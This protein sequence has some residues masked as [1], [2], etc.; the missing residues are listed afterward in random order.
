MYSTA[1]DLK[2][3]YASRAGRMVRRLIF[4]HI[5]AMWPD[6]KGLR[7]AAYGYGAPYLRPLME[8]AE[9]AV[10]LMPAV[11]GAHAWPEQADENNLACLVDENEW[12]LETESV[13][14]ILIVHGLEQAQTPDL[15]LQECWRVLKSN[16]RLV[17]VVPNRIGFWARSDWTPFGR[18]TPY[19]ISQI[20]QHLRNSLFVHERTEK[21]LFLPAF[22]S[23][24][25]LRTAYIFESIGRAVFP[26][27]AGVYVIEA[28]KQIYAG[29]SRSRV[30]NTGKRRVVTGVVPTAG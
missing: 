16:G 12:P 28:S 4:N 26:G 5:K 11:G 13:D 23:F 30:V 6:T 15:L 14:R 27:L 25:V 20:T 22:R 24:L 17:M 1:H 21:A 19:T 29:A 18:G 2:S 10:V 8:Q 7:I 3:F 9:R